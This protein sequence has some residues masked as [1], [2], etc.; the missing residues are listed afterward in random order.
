MRMRV[1]FD[2]QSQLARLSQLTQKT[3]Q[4]NLTTRRYEEQKIQEYCESPDWLVAHFALTDVYGDSGVVGLAIAH[5]T[6]PSRA[7]LDTFLMSCRVIGRNAETAFLDAVLTRLKN[8]G[9]EE[10][11]AE[12]L[13][14]SKNG[15]VK[16]FLPSHGFILGQEGRYLRSL[17]DVSGNVAPS[18]TIAIEVMSANSLRLNQR[19]KPAPIDGT[20]ETQTV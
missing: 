15:L 12:F 20:P 10:V 11:V 17:M 5:R 9:I 18:G 8:D 6:S 19:Q 3:N 13:P 14:T 4:F 1:W 7:E 2:D 16:D